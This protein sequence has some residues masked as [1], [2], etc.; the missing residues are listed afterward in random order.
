MLVPIIKNS[1]T[2]SK[3]PDESVHEQ[4]GIETVASVT[5]NAGG[6]IGCILGSAHVCG[7]FSYTGNIIAHKFGLPVRPTTILS[8][9][10]GALL[11][12]KLG[13]KIGYK[14]GKTGGNVLGKTAGLSVG[15]SLD[16]ISTLTRNRV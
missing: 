8:G 10:V 16:I 3:E 15:L 13:A 9:I 11:G 6:V 5:S 4:T 14:I 7:L 12:A 2:P 1:V